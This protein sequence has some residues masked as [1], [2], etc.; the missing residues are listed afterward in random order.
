MRSELKE[1]LSEI[2]HNQFLVDTGKLRGGIYL[3]DLGITA[4]EKKQLLNLFEDEFQIE[5]NERDERSIRTIR[6]TVSV[7]HQYLHRNTTT[8]KK[9]IAVQ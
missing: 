2:L 4:H 7:L 9:S 8:E 3:E 5:L 6:D 1:R